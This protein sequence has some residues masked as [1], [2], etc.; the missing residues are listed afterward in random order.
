MLGWCLGGFRGVAGFNSEEVGVGF[1]EEGW[2][3][4]LLPAWVVP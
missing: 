3:G 2:T 4:V 1:G